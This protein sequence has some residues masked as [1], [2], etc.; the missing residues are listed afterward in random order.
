[1]GKVIYEFM[2]HWDAPRRIW[3]KR[4]EDEL[5][6]TQKSGGRPMPRIRPF[7]LLQGPTNSP[8]FKP[9]L[10]WKGEDGI[11]EAHNIV[12]PERAFHRPADYDVL[13]FQYSGRAVAESEFGEFSL[14]PGES[15]HVPAGVAYRL[16]GSTDC[17]QLVTKLKKPV[18]LTLDLNNPLT[19]TV[20]EVRATGESNPPANVE[21]PQ[22]NGR[23]LEVTDFWDENL[24]PIVIERDHARLV[25]CVTFERGK[26]RE[27]SVMRVFDY[28]AGMTGKG[29]GP[30][31]QHYESEDFR[32]D[33]YNTEGEQAGFHRGMEDDEIWFQFRGHATNDTEWGVHE[34]D[35]GEMGYVP[36]GIAHRITGGEGFLRY[37]LYF[38]H[39]MYP[40]V[41]ASGHR[42]NTSFE[43][44]TV[45]YKELPSLADAK[46]KAEAARPRRGAAT[47]P[48]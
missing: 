13:V 35:P 31:P 14:A 28:F 24:A 48:S 27:P 19:E 10:L 37:V 39:P 41:D 43:V 5:I 9:A 4:D 17:R 30:G 42:G 34:L 45:S 26:G 11:I 15:L 6:G 25:G 44:R 3:F 12:G 20:F 21:I 18:K 23:I 1:M 32:T 2:T 7:D 40:Q 8:A 33:A 36:R 16:I 38:R 47:G 46:A 29:G 22:R